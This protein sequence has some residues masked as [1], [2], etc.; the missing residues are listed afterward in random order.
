MTK[1]IEQSR[2]S[3]PVDYDVY[4][5]IE[6]LDNALLTENADIIIYIEKSGETA[7]SSDL[8]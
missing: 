6:I 7:D 8:H 1:D 2:D 5:A 4:S 3:D